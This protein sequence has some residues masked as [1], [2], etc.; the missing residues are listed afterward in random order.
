MN[1]NTL[2]RKTRV[3]KLTEYQNII[4]IKH[5]GQE[6]YNEVKFDCGKKVIVS[7]SLSYWHSVFQNFERINRGVLIN[8][9]KV[10]S[11]TGTQ[12]V[13]LMDNSKFMYSRRKLKNSIL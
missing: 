7:Y 3:I 11:Q 8:P 1:N 5:L 2:I 6:P 9:E 10:I 13:E 4:Y 12:E